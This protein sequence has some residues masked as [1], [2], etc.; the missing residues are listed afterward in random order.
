MLMDTK[1]RRVML[2]DDSEIDNF[3][4]QRIIENANFAEEV[5]VYRSA[6]DAL[7]YLKHPQ[8]SDRLPDLIFLDV[9]MPLMDGLDFLKAFDNLA[10]HTRQKCKIIVLSSS[11]HSMDIHNMSQ[12]GYVQAFITKPLNSAALAKLKLDSSPLSRYP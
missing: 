9:N 7:D 12:Q 2:I 8:N 4:S 10:S 11:Y 6:I 3:V 5:Q 1:V